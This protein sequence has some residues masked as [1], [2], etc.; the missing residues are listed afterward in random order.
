MRLIILLLSLGA[1]V[2][3]SAQTHTLS[4]T[5]SSGLEPLGS[6]SIFLKGTSFRVPADSLGRYILRG[7]PP[8]TYTVAAASV[9]YHTV[10]KYVTLA[11]SPAVVL[12][13]FLR[14]DEQSLQEVVVTGTMK[15]I[16]RLES[17]V[18]VEVFSRAFFRK[19]PVPTLFDAL[20]HVN[21]VRPQLNCNIC[22]TGDIHM[23]GLEGPY[24]MILIDG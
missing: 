11:D 6:A 12:D 20:Q 18:P 8:G 3:A 14:R 17:S 7:I 10:S 22:N 15:E 5:V 9:G 19:N 23:N 21:G 2:P 13:F 16:S 24:T 4:G 1:I